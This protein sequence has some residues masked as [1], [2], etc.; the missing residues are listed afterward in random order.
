M[1]C[2]ASWPSSI[3]P[4]P[5]S[6]YA[7]HRELNRDSVVPR[8]KAVIFDLDDT[9]FDHTASAARAVHGSVPELGGTPTD[10][11]VAQWFVIERAQ[12]RPVR[13]RGR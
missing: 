12:L 10:E 5:C 8:V 11:L 7:N 2:A 4:W 3:S 9:L 1:Y 13:S 6:G